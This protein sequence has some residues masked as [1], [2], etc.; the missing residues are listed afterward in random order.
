MGLP[1]ILY[2][3]GGND[4]LTGGDDPFAGFDPSLQFFN[5]DRL[6]GGDGDD[7]L[8]GGFGIDQ[9]FG[10]AG[11]DVI[12]GD[13]FGHDLMSGGTGDDTYFIIEGAS[14]TELANEG[15][16][17]VVSS[18]SWTLGAGAHVEA[19]TTA[20][21]AGGA[22]IK[23]TG[24]GFAQVLI[25]NAGANALN[26]LGGADRMEGLGGNDTYYVD[27]A[28]DVVVEL[29]G[30]G[31]DVVYARANYTLEAGAEIEVLSTGSLSSTVALNLV[32]NGFSQEIY[33]NAGANLIQGGGGGD[34]LI[35]LGGDDRYLVE[36]QTDRVFENAGGGRDVVYARSNYVLAAG[37]SIEVLSAIDQSATTA[38]QLAGNAFGQ[39]V[40]GNAGN[41]ILE[42]GGGGDILVGFGGDD[43]YIVGDNT[44]RVF[45][46]AGGGRDV[47][48]TRG[49]YVL[50][51]GVSVEI[52]STVSQSAT[53]AM[54]LVG[55]SLN[56][57]IY[58]N[59]GVN[60]I[61]G[62][63]GTDYLVGLGGSD[64]YVVVGSG[65]H[66]LEAAGG[67]S[68]DVVYAK[69]SYGLEANQEVEVLSTVQQSAATAINLTGNN[70]V[71]EV[72]GNAGA[73]TLNGGAGSD[74][75]MSFGGTD[76]FAFTTALGATN[77][78]RIADFNVADDTIA[79]DDAVF[80]GL[81]TGA[82]AAGAFVNGTAAADADDRIL[83]NSATGQILF[84]AD[85]SGAGAA[86]LFAT[87]SAGTVLA[88]S[89]FMV[90]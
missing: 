30:K 12:H 33:G 10:E 87:V 42:G 81:A 31:R 58:G 28:G 79:L 8:I 39:E 21:Q 60:H 46:S 34:L 20:N 9:L 23:L 5:E 59:A 84:D 18:V 72:Y 57:E 32:G 67:G 36:G 35:G 54:K 51:A 86:V 1:D 6:Y 52:L 26:G 88:A 85:G 77:V 27:T 69:A 15:Y 83:Y 7:V 73:N 71:N 74:Y 78:D 62:G 16:D 17:V 14:V 64:V 70:L 22:A 68:R 89:D 82:L 37:V 41:N 45:E 4:R 2:G 48:Y 66:V 43:R 44:D 13:F 40:Y 76:T 11:N 25:G 24:N 55:S 90:I 56:Q 63:G 65:D 49:D 53:T 61:E 50:G 19:L 3:H 75:L 47:I 29:A 38:L 80:T